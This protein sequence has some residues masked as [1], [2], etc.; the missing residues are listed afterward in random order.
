MAN[1]SLERCPD[2]SGE[3]YRTIHDTLAQVVNENDQQVTEH[4]TAAWDIDHNLQIEAWNQ[5]QI[6]E[7]QIQRKAEQAQREQEAEALQLAEDKAEHECREAEKKKPKMNNFDESTLVSSVIVQRPAQYTLQ[8]LSTFNFI[9]LWYFSP[10][11]CV[12]ATRNNRSNANNTFG[13]S[14]VDERN[15]HSEIGHCCQ[16]VTKLNGGPQ[17]DLWNLPAGGG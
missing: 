13:I 11:G 10:A 6:I 12:E 14:K 5:Q 8:K 3:V 2:F 1:P 15:S 9:N 7:A 17:A 4:L 16:S